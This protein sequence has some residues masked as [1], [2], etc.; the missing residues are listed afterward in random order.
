MVVIENNVLMNTAVLVMQVGTVG[1]V[2]MINE[3]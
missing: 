2:M 3:L 1:H